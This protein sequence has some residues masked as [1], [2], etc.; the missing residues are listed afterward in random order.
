M[1]AEAQ[2]AGHVLVP[3]SVLGRVVELDQGPAGVGVLFEDFDDAAQLI[4]VPCPLPHP[5]PVRAPQDTIVGVLPQVRVV[6]ED[7]R[8]VR[9]G[10]V[11]YGLRHGKRGVDDACRRRVQ[12]A[13][14]RLGRPHMNVEHLTGRH[15]TGADPLAA[16]GQGDSA[17]EEF[18]NAA[19]GQVCHRTGTPSPCGRP[20]SA[21][22]ASWLM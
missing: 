21:A 14:P 13:R 17:D 2:R 10:E 20:D 1:E 22:R 15:T 7:P 16:L 18:G 8:G 3:C 5:R 4:H 12:Q 11:P 6:I 19:G 9:A